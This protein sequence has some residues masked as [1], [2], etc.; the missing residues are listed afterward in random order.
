MGDVKGAVHGMTGSL[1]A[2]TG[3]LLRN[4]NMQEKGFEKMN[5]EDSRLAAKRGE[6]AVGTDTRGTVVDTGTETGTGTAPGHGQNEGQG[7]GRGPGAAYG[8]VGIGGPGATS[9]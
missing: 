2:T 5:D 1:E 9:S 3:T 7:M 6:T 8:G 4:K